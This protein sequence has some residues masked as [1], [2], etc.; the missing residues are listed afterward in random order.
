M[1]S[2]CYISNFAAKMKPVRQMPKECLMQSTDS[3]MTD[4]PTNVYSKGFIQTF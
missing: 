2:K 3:E 1:A 4:T